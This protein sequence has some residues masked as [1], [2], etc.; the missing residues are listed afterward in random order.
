MST[1]LRPAQAVEKMK[2]FKDELMI[3]Y[4]CDCMCAYIYMYIHIYLYIYKY[5]TYSYIYTY[6]YIYKYMNIYRE[7]KMEMNRGGEELFAIRPTPF[8]EVINDYFYIVLLLSLYFINSFSFSILL[9]LFFFI[10]PFLIRSN[11]SFIR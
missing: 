3:R 6:I 8:H 5:E 4:I 1:A 10:M 7:R 9:A 2:T 11:Y